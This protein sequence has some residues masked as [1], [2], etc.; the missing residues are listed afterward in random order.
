[1]RFEGDEVWG[2]DAPARE[3]VYLDLWDSYLEPA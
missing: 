2:P 1:V 3:A